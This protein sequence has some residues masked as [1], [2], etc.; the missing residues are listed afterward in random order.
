MNQC[1]EYIRGIQRRTFMRSTCGGVLGATSAGFLYGST[2]NAQ[3][4]S[5]NA[6]S[7]VRLRSQRIR[8]AA[9]QNASFFPGS[10][11]NDTDRIHSLLEGIDHVHRQ[12]KEADLIVFPADQ[13]GL[14]PSTRLSD[15]IDDVSEK[16]G[17]RYVA[18]GVQDISHG[19]GAPPNPAF[20]LV[21][22]H[23]R[24]HSLSNNTPNFLSTDIG[25]VGFCTGSLCPCRHGE[26][27]KYGVEIM[28]HAISPACISSGTQAHKKRNSLFTIELADSKS[29]GRVEAI[30]TSVYGSNGEVLTQTGVSWCQTIIAT[31][32]VGELRSFR[33]RDNQ[34]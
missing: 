21:S 32:P 5:V 2:A 9:I 19:I 11:L 24:L 26:L 29:S 4:Q 13:L 27:S 18:F 25:V 17:D 1:E 10:E 12:V 23:G 6:S 3:N 20:F 31:L 16:A 28:I 22:P 15:L 8:V 30:A 33:D 14:I 7:L 34:A